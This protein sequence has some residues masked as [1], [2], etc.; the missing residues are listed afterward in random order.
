M[1]IHGRSQILA[2]VVCVAAC[3][4]ASEEDPISEAE[5]EASVGGA[6]PRL[7]GAAC[8]WGVADCNL[9]M[10]DVVSEFRR[11]PARGAVMGWWM[12]SDAPDVDMTNHWEG[13]VR[14]VVG[15]TRQLVITRRGAGAMFAT[16]SM[17]S[18][19]GTGLRFGAN[20]FAID[21]QLAQTPPPAND[22]MVHLQA[23]PTG[24]DHAGGASAVGRFVAVPLENGRSSRVVFFDFAAP[25]LPLWAS[26]ERPTIGQAGTVS[27]A[28]L[29]DGRFLVIVG[30]K[31]AG[32]LDF[33]VSTGTDLA[34]T[35]CVSIGW[36]AY[37]MVGTTINDW[38][39]GDYQS[40][41][42]LTQCDG[43]L[44]L[45]GMHNDGNRPIFLQDWADLF[46]ID[47]TMSG[48]F[49]VLTKVAKKHMYCTRGG[50]RQCN[51]DAASGAYVS[52]QGELILY[53]TEHGNDGPQHT[54]KM[55]EF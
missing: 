12:A 46:Q 15:H 41:T 40:L 54:V 27:I 14:P 34:T 6:A 18:R 49:F 10:R 7:V 48:G 20:R 29:R 19:N 25:G 22:A 21:A 39:F 43:S 2:A 31:D 32:I 1:S 5:I 26:L 30:R 23:E 9:C 24:Y 16:V 51:F 8:G 33:Y 53:S 52:S 37:W 47:A 42:L 38:N 55:V 50:T 36:W 17:G 44:F 11:V 35:G 28:K 3:A 45:L 4:T 13:I